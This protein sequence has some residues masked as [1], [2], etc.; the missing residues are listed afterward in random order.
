MPLFMDGPSACKAL[1]T[2]Y[3]S[4]LWRAAEERTKMFL[5]RDQ[6]HCNDRIMKIEVQRIVVEKSFG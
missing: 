4:G 6:D 1:L 2:G 3:C 5:I